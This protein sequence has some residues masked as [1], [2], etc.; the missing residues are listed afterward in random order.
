MFHPRCISRQRGA[1]RQPLAGLGLCLTLACFLGAGGR[2][3]MAAD[4]APNASLADERA[5]VEHAAR[6]K[7]FQEMLT[8][9]A[10]V[11]QFTTVGAA[12]ELPQTPDRY[13]IEEVRP[14][15]SGFWLFVA[16]IQYSGKDVKLPMSFEVKWAGETPVITLD[17]V[18]VPGF[19]SFSARILFHDQQYAGTWSAGD[20]GG[21]MFGHVEKLKPDAATPP[22]D[23]RPAENAAPA[24]PVGDTAVEK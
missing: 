8:G 19:G 6:E 24:N 4:P 18:L 10:L 9:V 14:L 1:S 16:R 13:V 2:L 20:H 21:H 23:A 15:K 12:N 11:G 17:N 3:A 7:K 5:A 22:G